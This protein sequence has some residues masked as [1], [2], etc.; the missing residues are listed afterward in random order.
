MPVAPGD[1]V[2][3]DVDVDGR[4]D[5]LDVVDGL[6]QG[7]RLVVGGD[8]HEDVGSRPLRG[9][10]VPDRLLGRRGPGLGDHGHS[11]GGVVDD[12]FDH[13][14]A[15]LGRHRGEFRCRSADDEAVD[16]AVDRPVDDLAEQCPVDVLL[17]VEGGGQGGEDT[18][19]V[20][21][22]P[23]SCGFEAVECWGG[24]SSFGC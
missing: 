9:Q 8:Q 3:H 21:G 22:H 15:L 6:G 20:L 10:R 12:E 4:G 17:G 7:Q 14:L 11:T 24:S 1:V 5:R 13:A 23:V 18:A 16:A 2:E 19:E